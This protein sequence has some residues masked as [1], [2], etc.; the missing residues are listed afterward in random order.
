LEYHGANKEAILD[1]IPAMTFNMYDGFYIY[2]PTYVP[3]TAKDADGMDVIVEEDTSKVKYITEDGTDTTLSMDEA[4]MTCKYTLTPYTPYS[5]RYVTEDE[6]TD[7]IVEYTL[8]NYIRIRGKIDEVYI[9]PLEGYYTYFGIEETGVSSELNTRGGITYLGEDVKPEKLT[10]IVSYK[11]NESDEISITEEHNYV[12]NIKQKKCYYN[13]VGNDWFYIDD[14]GIKT[15]I[16]DDDAWKTILVYSNGVMMPYYMKL[17]GGGNGIIYLDNWSD[18]H[19]DDGYTNEDGEW[20]GK[21]NDKY[22]VKPGSEEYGRRDGILDCPTGDGDLE[23]ESVAEGDELRNI[24]GEYTNVLYDFSA[25]N[26][27]LEAKLFFLT[28]CHMSK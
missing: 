17:E 11:E 3:E 7:I 2:G 5:A 10:E 6:K 16:D 25:I 9:Q 21:G 28:S 19:N 4:R 26:Y 23:L 27:Y 14:D 18:A 8:D 12:Y 15:A 22:M 13:D 1:Y 24:V 20:V